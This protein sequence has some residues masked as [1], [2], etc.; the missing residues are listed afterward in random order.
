MNKQRSPW[1]I[2]DIW[3]DTVTDMQGIAQASMINR[4]TGERYLS[5]QKLAYC[6]KEWLHFIMYHEEGHFVLQTDYEDDLINE[7]LADT[8]AFFK[9]MKHH[10]SLTNAVD[11]LSW[12]LEQQ[13]PEA[14]GN[15]DYDARVQ[16][17]LALAKQYD[18]Y[19]NGNLN[20]KL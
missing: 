6:N 14:A 17:I 10:N 16:N 1:E 3:Q 19:V 13:D 20:A 18:Y 12:M 7:L 8:Y 4:E 9:Y 15:P 5:R 2:R 11:A